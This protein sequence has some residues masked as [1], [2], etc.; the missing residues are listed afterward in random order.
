IKDINWFST[1]RV[2]HRVAS[3]FRKGR[4]FLLG[5]AA[6][7]H[8]PLGGQGMNTGIGDAINL[9]WKLEA[10]L[11]RGAPSSILDTYEKERIGFARQLVATTDKA[12][13]FVNRRSTL[14]TAIRTRMVPFVLPMFFHS[15]AVRRYVF[16]LVSQTQINYRSSA[17]STGVLHHIHGGDRLPWLREQDN[18]APLSTL[19]WQVHY[20][21]EAVWDLVDWCKYHE[22]PLHFFPPNGKIPP[23]TL[24]LV[25]PDGYV[26]WI[27]HRGDL[28]SLGRYVAQW[29]IS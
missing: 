10:V 27:G 12:F 4:V 15:A 24:C 14:A 6:H 3:S 11:T 25:R 23:R 18:Y 8:S 9:G 26:G 5:D 21:G 7:V 13:S 2:H 28:T 19:D 22:L 16:R 1:Y 29:R 17:L 20:Y